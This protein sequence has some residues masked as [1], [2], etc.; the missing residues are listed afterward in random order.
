MSLYLNISDLAS[1]CEQDHV[2][3]LLQ[4]EAVCDPGCVTDV[5]GCGAER[6]QSHPL[7]PLP[8]C[9]DTVYPRDSVHVVYIWLPDCT[10]LL[11]MAGVFLCL[12]TLYPSSADP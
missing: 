7:W 6:A 12:R 9:V 3:E 2:H 11:Q 5:V 1:Q 10:G 4:D 8:V